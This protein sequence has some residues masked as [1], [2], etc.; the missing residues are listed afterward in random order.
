M[1]TNF[2]KMALVAG[3]SAAMAGGSMSAHAVIQA[4]SAPA[5]LVPFVAT[6]PGA[7]T[8]FRI[9][10]PASVGVDTVINLFGGPNTNDQSKATTGLVTSVNFA[11]NPLGAPDTSKIHWIYLDNKSNEIRNGVFPVSAN[12]VV[13]FNSSAVPY[14]GGTVDLSATDA[15]VGYFL[16]VNQ[17]AYEGGAPVFSFNADAYIAWGDDALISNIPA[18]PLTDAADDSAVAEGAIT[19]T[20]LNNVL[21]RRSGNSPAA[22]PFGDGPIASP[23]ISGIRT[24]ATDKD[25]NS[26]GFRVIDLPVTNP[27]GDVFV[28]WSDRN[29]SFSFVEGKNIP[30]LSGNT[31]IYNCNES[32]L[33]GPTLSFED[34]LNFLIVS[35]TGNLSQAALDLRSGGRKH[36]HSVAIA[37]VYA[38]NAYGTPGD[39]ACFDSGTG[40]FV[41][42][43]AS[44]GV[45]YDNTKNAAYQSSVV[46]RIALPLTADAWGLGQNVVDRGFF[47]VK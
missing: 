40:G 31:L 8:T 11:Q 4:V 37:D 32:A 17:T 47:S 26:L 7:V 39:K 19:P 35:A 41:R 16:F 34:Q 1:K 33:S 10:V 42:W 18:Y 22:S 14:E 24:G 20:L 5:Q 45:N 15:G 44:P 46:F 43:V 30:A 9:E 23:I 29:S 13:E 38:Q 36:R 2:K 27:L 25:G 3:V 28:V 12:D 6:Y 21:E